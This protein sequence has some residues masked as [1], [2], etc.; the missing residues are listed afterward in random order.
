[1]DDASIFLAKAAASLAGAESELA[2]RRFDNCANRSYYACFQAAVA[3]LSAIGVQPPGRGGRWGH[4]YVQAR[5]VGDLINRQKV[6]SR[7]HSD[8]LERLFVVRQVAD[9]KL[10]NVSEVQAMRGVGRADRFV[11]AIHEWRKDR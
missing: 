10:Q 1:M 3:A 8:T 2:H 5:F 9:N 7:E 11:A 4:E 6:F